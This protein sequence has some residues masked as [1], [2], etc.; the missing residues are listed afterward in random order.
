MSLKYFE[1]MIENFSKMCKIMQSNGIWNKYLLK[2][3]EKN[4]KKISKLREQMQKISTLKH[5][6]KNTE[7]DFFIIFLSKINW[8]S[9]QYYQYSKNES[10]SKKRDN[11]WKTLKNFWTI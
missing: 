11:Y 7:I 10:L 4:I 1:K 6:P 5:R 3:M 2:H 8:Y 9:Y